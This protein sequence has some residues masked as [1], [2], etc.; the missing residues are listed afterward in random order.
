VW[1][2]RIFIFGVL[3]QSFGHSK[4]GIH[5]IWVNSQR[6]FEILDSSLS[7]C[8]VRQ[9]I[10]QMNAS[11]EVVL[12]DLQAFLVVEEALLKLLLQLVRLS[13]IEEGA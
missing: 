3:L 12:V 1:N 7:L 4:I 2:W 8:Q 13:Q 11:T 10:S 6:M 5:R 9:Q